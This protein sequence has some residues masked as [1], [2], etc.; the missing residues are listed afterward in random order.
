MTFKNDDYYDIRDM[1]KD[2]DYYVLIGGRANRVTKINYSICQHLVYLFGGKVEYCYD[3]QRQIHKYKIMNDDIGYCELSVTNETFIYEPLDV[4][5][6]N[7]CE[8]YDAYMRYKSRDYK[9]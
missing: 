4:R 6:M 9:E 7:M 3:V 1:F 5:M 8:E 2:Y